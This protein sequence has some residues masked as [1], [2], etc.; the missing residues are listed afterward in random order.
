MP[1]ARLKLLLPQNSQFSSTDFMAHPNFS[2]R[3]F[4]KMRSIGTSNFL[5]KTTVRRG[6][7]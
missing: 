1:I 2:R 6:S 4:E 5:Q 3:V 7:M